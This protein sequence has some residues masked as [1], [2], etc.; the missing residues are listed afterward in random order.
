[1]GCCDIPPPY[2]ASQLIPEASS[3][4]S[5]L[6]PALLPDSSNFSLPLPALPLYPPLPILPPHH[7]LL[8][9]LLP[10]NPYSFLNGLPQ[11]QLTCTP[12]EW[13]GRQAPLPS[14][15][16]H[17]L[18]HSSP[19]HRVSGQ[20]DRPTGW[21][22]RRQAFRDSGQ[23]AGIPPPP[24]FPLLSEALACAPLP[25]LNTLPTSI[26]YTTTCIDAAIVSI[27]SSCP[28]PPPGSYYTP[29][30]IDA[31]GPVPRGA[32]QAA[33]LQELERHLQV[34]VCGGGGSGRGACRSVCGG[35][36]EEVVGVMGGGAFKSASMPYYMRIFQSPM[37]TSPPGPPYDAGRPSFPRAQLPPS[38]A[39]RPLPPAP[40]SLL[41]CRPRT[42]K[43]RR[44]P[45]PTSHSR[46]HK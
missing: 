44:T 30:R 42:C 22:G 15:S 7:Q 26:Y 41:R 24:P 32:R 46:S 27:L 35:G 3:S 10:A 5:H 4:G 18:R 40:P 25:S 17:C 45:S 38:A 19:A 9:A 29:V 43:C 13:S 14:S 16:S 21:A 11:A 12:G 28:L 8:Q 20:T 31:A 39:R 36:E 6:M 1:M 2:P 34:C 23:V 33:E 37:S